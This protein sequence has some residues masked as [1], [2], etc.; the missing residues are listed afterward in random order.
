MRIITLGVN[1]QTAPVELREQLALSGAGLD[2]AIDRL[3]R[4]YPS[5]ELVILCTCNRTELYLA[6]PTHE[7]PSID[8]LRATVAQLCHVDL[9]ALAAASIHREQEHARIEQEQA[10]N[11]TTLYIQIDKEWAQTNITGVRRPGEHRRDHAGG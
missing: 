1:H 5:A 10:R 4:D 11:L 2:D 3:R 7:S 9:A 8:E 6:R